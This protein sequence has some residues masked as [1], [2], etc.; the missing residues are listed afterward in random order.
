MS[1]ARIFWSKT[2]DTILITISNWN[3]Y[4]TGVVEYKEFSGGH[5]YLN[6]HYKNVMDIILNDCTGVD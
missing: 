3:N 5:F 1:E 4:F 2:D 6:S